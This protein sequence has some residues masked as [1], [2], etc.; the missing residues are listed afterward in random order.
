MKS[1]ELVKNFERSGFMFG[2]VTIVSKSISLTMI[3][4]DLVFCMDGK[5]TTV[6][7][8]RYFVPLCRIAVNTE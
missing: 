8:R 2:M 3:C 7:R 4:F 5:V 6:K 1:R